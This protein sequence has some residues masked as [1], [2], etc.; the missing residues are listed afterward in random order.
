MTMTELDRMALLFLPGISTAA[1]V[2]TVSGRGV[3]MDVVQ[4]SLE[5]VGGSIDLWSQPGVG[6]T[7]T[8]NVPLTLAI[9]PALIV[10]SGRQRYT[11]PQADV[12]R[13]IQL[14]SDEAAQRLLHIG[15]A[16]FLRL[17]GTLLP[18]VD[19]ADYLGVTPDR[20]AERNEIVV[21]RRLERTYGLIVD[22]VGDTVEAVVKPL[23]RALRGLP[24]YAGVTVLSD[25]R[26]CLILEAA[27]PAA[28]ADVHQHAESAPTREHDMKAPGTDLLTVTVGDNHLAVPLECVDRLIQ[29]P[30]ENVEHSGHHEV[31]QNGGSI[32][33][34]IRVGDLLG[35][36]AD[37]AG[38]SSQL[39]IAICSVARGR[40]GL[41]VERIVDISRADTTTAETVDDP[42]VLGRLVVD[43]RVTALLDLPELVRV[44]L[45]TTVGGM[46]G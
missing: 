39:T 6:T 13:V 40:V 38:V 25:G 24:C 23:P 4:V 26:P 27:A 37:K 18:L 15:A 8:I 45:D 36:E 31:L 28:D 46:H 42:C 21:I 30:T 10:D 32:L 41:I 33:P 3:G 29:A 35:L 11:I 17:D 1:Q 14:D 19:L 2:T 43:G 7:F 20:D 9:L 16:R 34:L 44:G 12:R 22:C 5:R